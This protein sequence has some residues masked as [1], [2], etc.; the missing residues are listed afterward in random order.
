MRSKVARDRWRLAGGTL[1]V[2][3]GVAAAGAAGVERIREAAWQRAH[4]AAFRL[5]RPVPDPAV[6]APPARPAARGEAVARLRV[7]R[8]D[9]DV[10][11]AEG[12]DPRTLRLGPGHMEG[13]A[14][15]GES[16]NCIIA[17]HRDGPFGRLRSIHLGD[18]VEIVDGSG[19]ASYRVVSIDVVD[20]DD[21][22]SLR[23]SDRPVLTLVTCYPFD[24]MGPAPRR[25][26]VQGELLERRR[27]SQL[28]IAPCSPGL[29]PAG[30]ASLSWSG[31]RGA[32]RATVDRCNRAGTR[33]PSG[34]SGRGG[35]GCPLLPDR[36]S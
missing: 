16:D 35:E 5:E 36:R 1:C 14:R 12:T 31:D 26:V 2:L 28:P 27:R 18:R 21:A 34:P 19:L 10:V 7:H 23:P 3:A 17:G 8:L 9:L 13:S 15:P 20:R 22:S 11:V 32:S 29:D 33:N 25:L 30:P 6:P 24:H 4:A